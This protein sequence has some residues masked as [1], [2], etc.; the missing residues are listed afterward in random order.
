MKHTLRILLTGF[1]LSTPALKAEF[2][3]ADLGPEISQQIEKESQEAQKEED[4]FLFLASYDSIGKAK[5]KNHHDDLSFG[6]KHMRFSQAVLIG[7]FVFWYNPEYEEGA[8]ANLGYNITEIDWKNNPFWTK[9]NYHTATM[10]LTAFTNRLCD[11]TWRAQLG[12]NFDTD[13]LNLSEY[14][15]F[16]SFLWGRLDYC[17]NVGIHI[18]LIAQTGM[19]IDRLYPILGFDWK[20]S[21]SWML[22]MVFPL[23]I[24]LIY[25][26]DC[27]WSLAAE[28][29]FF[30]V[31]Y[32]VGRNEN[33]SRGLVHYT[34]AGLEF[35]AIYELNEWITANAHIG[36]D[37]GGRMIVANRHDRHSK[38]FRFNGAGYYGGEVSLKF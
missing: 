32:R 33:L 24:S 37:V 8:V 18:G 34:S 19:K 26:L 2:E 25:K 36:Y 16:D 22:N 14:S 27:N 1:I 20:I 30:D 3:T 38:R 17:E 21:D 5:L 12:W 11:W 23:N 4:P 9:K 6:G 28:A 15:T 29:R 35:A 13:H 31:R 10:S 7:S